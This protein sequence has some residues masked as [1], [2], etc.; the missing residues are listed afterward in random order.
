MI[1][2]PNFLWRP[3]LVSGMPIFLDILALS[4]EIPIKRFHENPP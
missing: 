4:A 3:D 1:K 2:A